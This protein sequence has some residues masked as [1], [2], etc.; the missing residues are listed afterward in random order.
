MSLKVT[1]TVLALLA[2][3]ALS[4]HALAQDAAGNGTPAK[5]ASDKAAAGGDTSGLET[6]DV[7]AVP[8]E[9]NILPTSLTSAS[10]YGIDLNVM[11]T[12]RNSTI[13]SRAQLDTVNIED[14]RS[15]SYLTSSSYT[16][17]AFGGPNI[18]RIR[19]QFGD[20]F[21]NGMRSSFTSN[22]YGAELSFNSIET[23]NITKGPASVIDGPG[24][25]VGGTVDFITKL[26]DSQGFKGS[27][28]VDF[29]TT[30]QR[31]WNIDVGGPIEG[32]SLSYRVSYTGQQ[33][34][35]YFINHYFDE[36]SIYGVILYQPSADYS[37]QFNSEA[38]IQ[39]YEENVGINRVNQQLIDHDLYLTGAPPLADVFGYGTQVV[40]GNPVKL[41]PRITIDENPDTSGHSFLYNAQAIQTFG[42]ADG[43]SLSNNTFFNYENRDNQATYYYADS[44]KDTYSIESRTDLSLKFSTPVSDGLTVDSQMDI[45][46]TGRF[47]HVNYVSNFNNEPVS[48][49]DLSGNPADWVFPPT[50]QAAGGAYQYITADGRIQWGVP[51]RDPIGAGDTSESDTY[52]FA[53]YLEHRMQFTPELSLMYGGRYDLIHVDEQDPLGPLVF[54]N[55]ITGQNE[56]KYHSTAWYGLANGNVSPVYQFAD[57]GSLYFTYDYTQSVSGSSGDGGFG[58]Y[59]GNDRAALQLTS[60]LYEGGVKFNLLDKKLFWGN[61]LFE[62]LRF[63]PTG[64]VGNET[65]KAKITGFETELNYQPERQFYVTSSYSY[66]RTRLDTAAGFWNFPAQPGLNVDGAGTGAIFY[67]GQHYND[68]GV[69]QHVFNFLGNYRFDTGLGFRFGVQVTGPIDTTTSGYLDIQKMATSNGT[70]VA[71][72]VASGQLP[73]S[74]AARNGYYQSPQIPWQYTMNAAVYYEFDRYLVTLSLYNLTN[75][76]NWESS[77]PYYGNDFL[78]RADPFSAELSLKVKF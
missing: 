9:E 63:V 2:S 47:A 42:L 53:L 55:Y 30:Y 5:P 67:G 54:Y 23:V 62:Q 52:D 10:T 64:P 4:T 68:P 33:D 49:Y 20:V 41:N 29:S 14:T 3:T 31:H 7:R 27:A 24:P 71:G 40:M 16:D 22:G 28:T 69:P 32:T 48:V 13:L 37:L 58:T 45:G 36:H 1:A 72:L 21:F 46:G 77:D 15:F 8:V 17:S 26:P 18:P 11:E 19:G 25:G 60:R 73:A 78:V 51:G 50:N 35:S 34:D 38:T 44:A 59:G 65:A 76:N 12:P 61:A 56:W 75:Q 66:I 74:V 57:W 70:T 6:V 43:V 39:N